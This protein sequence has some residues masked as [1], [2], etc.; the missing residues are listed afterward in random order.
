MNKDVVRVASA[1]S[2][3][4]RLDLYEWL[5]T[6]PFHTPLLKRSELW[7]DALAKEATIAVWADLKETE[8]EDGE[9]FF[10]Y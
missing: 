3:K 10:F 6:L 2:I 9:E 8:D 1:T 5:D 7:A 4:D